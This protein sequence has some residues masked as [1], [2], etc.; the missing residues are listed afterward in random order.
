MHRMVLE[1]GAGAE[2][3]RAGGEVEEGAASSSRLMVVG[4]EGADGAK[5]AASLAAQMALRTASTLRS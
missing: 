4:K 5:M 2:A 1:E 3:G